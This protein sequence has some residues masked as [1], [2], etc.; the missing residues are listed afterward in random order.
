MPFGIVGRTGPVIRQVVGF[1]D[2]STGRGTFGGEFRVRHCPQGPI[3][4][5][6]C[7]AP[8]RGPLAKLL[9]AHLL[10]FISTRRGLGALNE[11]TAWLDKWVMT[12]FFCPRCSSETTTCSM[13]KLGT[14]VQFG[15]RMKP[16]YSS[17]EKDGQ[18]INVK[19]EKNIH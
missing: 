2:R 1:G 11:L 14:Q 3:G 17:S 18:Y 4:R 13:L 15:T 5:T 6:C 16:T 9:W 7:T 8:R 19:V 12:E 10:L